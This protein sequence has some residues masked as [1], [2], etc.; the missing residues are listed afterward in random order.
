MLYITK[1][2]D[3]LKILIDDKWEDFV[4]KNVCEY[5]KYTKEKFC[6]N[7]NEQQNLEKIV[8]LL[9]ILLITPDEREKYVEMMQS[10]SSDSG[11]QCYN[12]E[13]LNLFDPKLRP[14]NTR[15]MIKNK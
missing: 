10:N 3:Y 14:I 2:D 1:I 5:F 6:S 7:L 15:P 12:V 13:I 9:Y 4:V 8:K 11:V